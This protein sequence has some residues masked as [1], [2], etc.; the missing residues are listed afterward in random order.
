MQIPVNITSIRS[1]I[2]DGWKNIKPRDAR[3]LFLCYNNVVI[4]TIGVM[5]LN[6]KLIGN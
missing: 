6:A 3:G 1:L 2:V 5:V 4:N